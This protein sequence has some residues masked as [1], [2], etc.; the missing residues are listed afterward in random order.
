MGA[1]KCASR[2]AS[3]VRGARARTEDGLE[4]DKRGDDEEAHPERAEDEKLE[5]VEIHLSE[6]IAEARRSI[7]HLNL[8]HPVA[9]LCLLLDAME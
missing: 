6:Q 3:R 8:R 5:E 7:R 9:C 1:Q 2:R 4:A